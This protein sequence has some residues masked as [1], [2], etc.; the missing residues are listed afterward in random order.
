M[1]KWPQSLALVG[2][3][4]MGGAM[5]KGWLA[6][7]L[8]PAQVAIIDPAPSQEIATLAAAHGVALNPPIEGRSAPEALILAIK[9]QMLDAAAPQLTKLAGAQT[10]VVSI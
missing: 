6:G 10:L 4:K 5:L 3:G 1:T 2:A 9:P 7:G 8:A